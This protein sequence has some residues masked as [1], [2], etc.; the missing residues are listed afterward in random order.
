MVA[1]AY[2]ALA[3]VWLGAAS[4]DAGAVVEVADGLR[5]GVEGVGHVRLLPPRQADHVALAVADVLVRLLEHGVNVKC[6]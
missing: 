4:A 2:L 1:I 3:G 6:C 5:A